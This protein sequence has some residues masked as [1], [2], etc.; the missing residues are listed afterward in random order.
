MEV[1]ILVLVKGNERYVFVF[2]DQDHK[3]VHRQFG[4][5]ASNPKLSFSWFDAALLSER[6]RALAR[7][8]RNRIS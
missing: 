6:V 3:K 8:E 5:M 7:K 1:S 4:R 2:G